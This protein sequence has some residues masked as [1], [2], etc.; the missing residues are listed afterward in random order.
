MEKHTSSRRIEEMSRLDALIHELKDIDIPI[1]FLT[2]VTKQDLWWAE[3][4]A[5]SEHYSNDYEARINDLKN[6]LG[7][8]GVKL[9]H[10]FL[11]V[12]QLHSNFRTK[13]GKVLAGVSEGYDWGHHL[14]SIKKLLERF[15]ELLLDT[16]NQ[17]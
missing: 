16:V 3:R 15:D 7:E 6:K 17:G 9:S 5:V 14:F 13:N 10:N 1:R 12:S 11:T 2:I 8:K 4:D